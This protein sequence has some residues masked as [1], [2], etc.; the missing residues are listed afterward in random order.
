MR[1]FRRL[2]TLTDFPVTVRNGSF[3]QSVQWLRDIAYL[4]P[5]EYVEQKTARYFDAVLDGLKPSLFID[6]GANVGSYTLRV[7]NRFPEIAVWLFEPDE[8][9]IR[10][11]MRTISSN[12]LSKATL[13]PIALGNSRRLA[14]FLVDGVSGSA[15]TFKDQ[16]S[17]TSSLQNV[18]GLSKKRLVQLDTLDSF[19]DQMAGYRVL[20][21][22]DAEDCEGEVIEGAA[23]IL[24]E[25]RPFL[26]VESFDWRRLSPL[27]SFDYIIF[28]IEEGCNYLACPRECQAA[29]EAEWLPKHGLE[30]LRGPFGSG[31][32]S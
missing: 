20:C 2:A 24:R 1:W 29:L 4:L 15:G 27:L 25:I 23:R 17:N 30:L 22:I 21:K 31:P 8:T 14:E 7:L 28:D 26:I 16:R 5:H 9:N 6:V 32:L 13:H 19:A 11:L 10:L 12:H 18:Y 3:S